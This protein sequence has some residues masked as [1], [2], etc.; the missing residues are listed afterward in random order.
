MDKLS[1]LIAAGGTGGHLFPALAVIEEL[2]EITKGGIQP[3][4]VG[5]QSKIEGRTVPAKGYQFYNLPISGLGGLLSLKTLLLPAKIALSVLKCRSIIKKHN[6]RLVLCT[7]AYLS[8]PA[9]AAANMEGVPLVLMESN[10]MPGKAIKM[11]AG[12][13]EL[14]ITSFEESSRYYSGGYNSK[15]IDLGNPVRKSLMEL[16][17]REEALESLGLSFNKTT[18]FV[19]GGSLGAS[20]INRSVEK[21]INKFPYDTTQFIWQTGKY[22]NAPVQIPNNV[23]IMQFIDD[24]ASAYAAADLVICRSGATTVSELCVTGKPSI[25]VPYPNAA[26]NEQELNAG[27]LVRTDAAILIQDNEIES[28]LE[29]ELNRLINDRFARNRMAMAAKQLAKPDAALRSAEKILTLIK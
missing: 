15:I 23:K 9:G 5:N 16:P 13:A 7:G 10:L 22:Y 8:Y 19:F 21:I 2:E 29:P 3:I 14:I 1:I 20:S 12:K 25:L 17:S 18:V 27:Y 26:N 11:L 6:I 28:K 4:F 24:M